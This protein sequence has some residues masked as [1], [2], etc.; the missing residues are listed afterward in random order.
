MDSAGVLRCHNIVVDGQSLCEMD[1]DRPAVSLPLKNVSRIHLAHGFVAE[2]R[3][4]VL[5]L[6]LFFTALG[7]I[8][9]V[10]IFQ[11]LT[12]G[13][14]L[15]DAELFMLGWLLLGPYLVFRAFKRG[16]YLEAQSKRSSRK[17]IF[18]KRAT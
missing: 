8:W 11:W 18:A 6:G 10:R 12:T 15:V 16:F 1:G 4:V 13:G 2:R 17:L 9:S 7:V 14:T 3:L 5:V